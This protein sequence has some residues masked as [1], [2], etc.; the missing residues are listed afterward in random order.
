VICATRWLKGRPD[1]I[2]E[3]VAVSARG[4][5]GLIATLAAALSDDLCAVATEGAV[6]SLTLAI[7][8][9]LSQPQWAYAANV[10]KAADVPQWVALCA[11]RPFLA[12]NPVGAGRRPLA[13]D[14]AAKLFGP[15]GASYRCLEPKPTEAALSFL[16]AALGK[17]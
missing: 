2:G 9:P 12:V 13:K 17:R 5:V 14:E 8:D 10:L 11:P 4:S 7:D 16:E 1:V 15:A 6:G 3:K